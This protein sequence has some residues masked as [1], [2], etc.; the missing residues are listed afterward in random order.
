MYASQW[1]DLKVETNCGEI[2]EAN[3]RVLREIGTF[4]S[5]LYLYSL[6]LYRPYRR[7]YLS[8]ASHHG[9]NNI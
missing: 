1:R 2:C 9:G 8:D 6:Y 3:V 4:H 7:T 5:S